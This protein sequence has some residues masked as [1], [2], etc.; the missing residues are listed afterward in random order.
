VI[1][2]YGPEHSPQHEWVFNEADLENARVVWARDMG[3]D[4]NRLLI[5]YFRNRR[6]WLLEVNNDSPELVPY[7]A[8]ERPGSD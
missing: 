6:P 1:V 7:P 4:E 3:V 8:G 2:R 5:D